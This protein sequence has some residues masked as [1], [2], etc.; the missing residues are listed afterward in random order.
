V[1]ISDDRSSASPAGA[2]APA[3]DPGC[4]HGS[5]ALS[6]VLHAVRLT[7][8]L[9]FLVDASA[10]WVAEAPAGRTLA[11]AILPGA[12]RI[13]SY[14]VITH[15][16]AWCAV[17]GHEAVRLPPGDVV[18]IPHGDPY[19]LCS[20]RGLRS[21][22]PLTAQLDWFRQM[23][24]GRLPFV[25]TEGGGGP[26]RLGVVCGFLGCDVVPFNP[27]IA[28]LPSVVRVAPPDPGSGDRLG[29]LVEFAIAEPREKRAGSECVRLRISELMF[30]EVVRRYLSELPAEQTG[31][32]AGL[33]DP[34]VGRAL[35]LLHRQPARAWTLEALA[36]EAGLSRSLL[37]ERFQ[38]FVGQPPMRYLTRWRMQVAA[39]L[40]SERGVKVSAIAA[41][42][43]Y[44]SEAAFSRAFKRVT[45]VPPAAWRGRAPDPRPPASR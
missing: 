40:L 38:H 10:P 33:R 5:D 7:G 6:D 16:E 9:F 35:A 20:P 28:A 41:R 25:V 4:P 14:H 23:V 45:G 30:V 12:Q 32:L 8:S 15:G 34:C 37:A 44:D 42:V 26:E 21:E 3:D 1:S 31:W 36:H 11:P 27:V 2:A 24:A 29:R 43:G 22:L 17:V 19:A 18:V 39:R 13:I